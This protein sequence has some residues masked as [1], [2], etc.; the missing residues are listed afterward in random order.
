MDIA[1]VLDAKG[2]DVATIDPDALVLL[3]IHQMSSRNIGALV[4]TKDGE[5]VLGV[6]SE[7][8]VTRA[9]VRHG[10]DLLSL[11]VRDVMSRAVPVC[12]PDESAN[13]C[14]AT[15]TRS[16][17]RHLPVVVDGTLSGLVSIGDLV[18]HRLEELEL[19]RNVLR[20]TYLVQR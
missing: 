19:E 6:I 5:T 10:S 17:H 16:R 1:S 14:M 13:S 7:R 2:W 18:K 11:R 15:M 20:R 8:D 3:A 4:A 9:L 12:R